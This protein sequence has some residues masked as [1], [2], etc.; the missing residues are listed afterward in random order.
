MS[1][2]LLI[3]ATA[4]AEEINGIYSNIEYMEKSSS[5]EE[6]TVGLVNENLNRYAIEPTAADFLD[7]KDVLLTRLRTELA[8]AYTA[9]NA[10]YACLA[11]TTLATP[12]SFAAG[13]GTE[14][15]DMTWLAATNAQYY[16]IYVSDVNDINTA[17]MITETD[18]LAYTATGLDTGTLYYFWCIAKA[19]GYKDSVAAT[20]SQTPV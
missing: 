11:Y 13:A 2:L 20:T 3:A 14:E 18:A 5:F 15:V 6:P 16:K 8:A 12:G 7:F 19:T 4:D 10:A 1:S 9:F 17:V